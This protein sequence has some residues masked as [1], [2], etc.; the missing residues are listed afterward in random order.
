MIERIPPRTRQWI[1]HIGFFAFCGV[2][3]FLVADY[4]GHHRVPGGIVGV[5]GNGSVPFIAF[6]PDHAFA[7]VSANGLPEGLSGE[8]YELKETD[9]ILLV[10]RNAFPK[11]FTVTA[12]LQ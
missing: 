8:W 5:W 2:G 6:Y 11:G 1:A 7:Y 4:W 9:T 12:R 10:Y 3:S